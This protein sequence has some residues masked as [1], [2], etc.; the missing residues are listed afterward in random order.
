[1]AGVDASPRSGCDAAIAAGP[2]LACA[3][4]VEALRRG[5]IESAL[6]ADPGGGSA[7]SAVVFTTR[8]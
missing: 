6:I 7:A 2:L 8:T 3:A 4:A 5:E 1:M